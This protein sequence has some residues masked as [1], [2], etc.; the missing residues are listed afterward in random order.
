MRIKGLKIV[1]LS[2]KC[3]ITEAIKSYQL[4][5]E[6]KK[7]TMTMMQRKGTRPCGM[8]HMCSLQI[9]SLQRNTVN[10]HRLVFIHSHQTLLMACFCVRSAHSTC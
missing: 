8:S 3:Q 7:I 2:M 9:N 4:L 1:L 10:V 5:E 6:E